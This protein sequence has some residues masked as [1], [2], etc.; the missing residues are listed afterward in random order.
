MKNE[1]GFSLI[2]LVIFIII[3]ALLAAAIAVVGLPFLSAPTVHQDI[4]AKETAAQCMEWY[5]GQNYVNGYSSITCPS[6]TVPGFCTTPTGYTLSV[7]ITCTTYNSDTNYKTIVVTVTGFGNASL[8]Y[9]I[10]S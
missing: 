4:F 9:M 5:L 10:A 8:S 2:E 7:N 1:L 3:M 6:T